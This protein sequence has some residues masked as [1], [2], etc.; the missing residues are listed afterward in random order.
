MLMINCK[1]DKIR[2][3]A[4]KALLKMTGITEKLIPEHDRTNIRNNILLGTKV[5]NILF[6]S[7]I[8]PWTRVLA[9]SDVNGTNIYFNLKRMNRSDKSLAGTFAHELS[10]IFGYV[11]EGNYATASNLLT[12]PYLTGQWVEDN[13]ED[14]KLEDKI[15]EIYFNVKKEEYGK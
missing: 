10:H 2:D 15:S 6:Y 5:V 8:N 1:N 7:T 9:K 4:E 13:Y 14:I 3:I 11:H 12:I